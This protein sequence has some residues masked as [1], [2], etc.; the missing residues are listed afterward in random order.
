ME[1]KNEYRLNWAPQE[2][3]SQRKSWQLA[4]DNALKRQPENATS[5]RYAGNAHGIM[6]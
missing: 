6:G 2:Y 5:S 1:V 3:D 4:I